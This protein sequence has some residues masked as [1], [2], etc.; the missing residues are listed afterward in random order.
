MKKLLYIVAITSL[1][2]DHQNADHHSCQFIE[3][4]LTLV[5]GGI[6]CSKVLIMF[7]LTAGPLS[8]TESQ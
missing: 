4:I 7:F 8:P 5:R 2:V 3:Y 1:P 6:K